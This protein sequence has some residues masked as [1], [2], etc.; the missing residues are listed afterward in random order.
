M[1]N[2]FGDIEK[3]AIERLQEFEES[4]LAK[5]PDGYYLAY[6][7]GKSCDSTCKDDV[8]RRP[9]GSQCYRRHGRRR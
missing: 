4:A 5:C 7:G 3:V 6:S 9:V 1:N 2:L 8:G